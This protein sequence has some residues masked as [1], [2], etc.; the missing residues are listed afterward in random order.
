MKN[1]AELLNHL[2]HI[3]LIIKPK[4]S[5]EINGKTVEFL[6]I[7][8][9]LV[10]RGIN[11]HS[12]LK[13]VG[14]I[15]ILKKFQI[16]GK[17]GEEI[18]IK[19]FQIVGLEHK[20]DLL[21]AGIIE[22]IELINGPISATYTIEAKSFSIE[23]DRQKRKRSFQ[24]IKKTYEDI[25]DTVKTEGKYER[26][27]LIPIDKVRKEMIN[28]LVIQYEET[29]W[30][31]L[32]RMASNQGQCLVVEDGKSGLE[33][34]SASKSNDSNNSQSKQS[35]KRWC[36]WLG[37]PANASKKLIDGKY[38]VEGFENKKET[39]LKLNL[40]SRYEIGDKLEYLHFVYIVTESTIVYKGNVIE[41][42]YKLVKEN[43]LIINKIHNENIAGRGILAEVVEIGVG[44]NLTRVRVD[45]VFDKG[46]SHEISGD[47]I[48]LESKSEGNTR[49]GWEK[50]WFKYATPFS[51]TNSG[52]YIMPEIK[53]RLIVF[54]MNS[55]ES[56][57][58]VGESI[59]DT[60][61]I[62]VDDTDAQHKRIMI[63]TGQQIILSEKLNKVS[64]LGN[65]D[66]TVYIDADT[67]SIDLLAG[68]AKAILKK[69]G[70][71]FEIGDS[72][73]VM[74]KD[75]IEIK[76]GSASITLASGGKVSVK[77]S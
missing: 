47:G 6:S 24:D 1:A 73:F 51:G 41:N 74:T 2:N 7:A 21:F 75:G 36:I 44:E 61:S 35:K 27:L 40:P 52:I 17:V 12:E 28:D 13:V 10:K 53:D 22:K 67:D 63:P 46:S 4:R 19:A 37:I 49:A 8:D 50:H 15:D 23:L 5:V 72:K 45:F 59:R 25:L 33:E 26:L 54:F 32:K 70:I 58:Y 42:E 55:N 66:R 34:K 11:Q 16:D 18:Q 62:E 14:N 77:G 76:C 57:A 68:E 65:K 48:K 20:S 9:V 64:I 38:I 69:E 31:F 60:N 39:Y 3:E 43:R 56:S 30:E 71:S 29:D